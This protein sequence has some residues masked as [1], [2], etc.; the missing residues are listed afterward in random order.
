[1]MYPEL[2]ESEIINQGERNG[3]VDGKATECK[4]L[5]WYRHLQRMRENKRQKNFIIG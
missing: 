2:G 4:R 5:L 1:V 3:R